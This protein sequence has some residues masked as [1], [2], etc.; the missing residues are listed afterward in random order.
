MLE[1]PLSLGSLPACFLNARMR[2]Y[3]TLEFQ[4]GGP[5]IRLDSPLGIGCCSSEK[6]LEQTALPNTDFYSRKYPG[7][8]Q[9]TILV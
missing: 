6:P 5:E 8:A 9:E 1:G 7:L 4:C 2:Q 3:L